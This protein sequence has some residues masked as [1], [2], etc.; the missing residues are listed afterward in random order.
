MFGVKI[1]LGIIYI[2][3]VRKVRVMRVNDDFNI[4]LKIFN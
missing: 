2:Y 3:I 1:V 4:L